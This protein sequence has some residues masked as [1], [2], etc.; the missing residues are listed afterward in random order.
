MQHQTTWPRHATRPPGTRSPPQRN[1]RDASSSKLRSQ[2]GPTT[3]Q[4][5]P[6]KHT[7]MNSR[8]TAVYTGGRRE[9]P[10]YMPRRT[11]AAAPSGPPRPAAPAFLRRTYSGA[12]SPGALPS[13]ERSRSNS[14]PPAYAPIAPRA[15]PQVSQPR[16]TIQRTESSP[17]LSTSR[18]RF[19]STPSSPAN[20]PPT[21]VHFAA[22]FV[23]DASAQTDESFGDVLE[24]RD[25][26][27]ARIAIQEQLDDHLKQLDAIKAAEADRI[28]TESR[29]A[30]Q[31]KLGY[32]SKLEE[33]EQL[34][35]QAAEEQRRISEAEAARLAQLAAKP[36]HK[37]DDLLL[38]VE[39]LDLAPPKKASAAAANG[40][41]GSLTT[42]L[43]PLGRLEEMYAMLATLNKAT[44]EA[45][46]LLV[47]TKPD[48]PTAAELEAKDNEILQLKQELEVA[49]QRAAAGK[50]V[51]HAQEKFADLAKAA[52]VHKAEE[53]RIINDYEGKISKL[54]AQHASEM[55]K[56]VETVRAAA[57]R[58][59]EERART[60]SFEEAMAE[61]ARRV[62]E[63]LSK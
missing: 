16:R 7:A 18:V 31:A 50:T 1:G 48:G 11:A 49:K 9:A 56:M 27:R 35:R 6:S 24:L 51:L 52:K 21:A 17:S 4:P 26:L 44:L 45:N 15:F 58:L 42:R 28:L 30:E 23:S 55:E 43:K 8:V 46:E 20:P 38:D 54:S 62:D 25:R 37:D 34:K 22:P 60:Q 13:L 12:A 57:A 5:T 14:T 29:A 3:K 59:A 33:V 39:D 10:L 63:L 61:Q 36:A 53:Q 41:D 19:N 47:K 40:A 2:P 32:L